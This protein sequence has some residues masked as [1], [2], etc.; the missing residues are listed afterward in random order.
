MNMK[1]I[2]KFHKIDN[3][4]FKYKDNSL[5]ETWSCVRYELFY[6]VFLIK[7]EIPNKTFF[8]NLKYLF[9]NF[10]HILKIPFLLKK[11]DLLI[12]DVGRYKIYQNKINDPL[13]Q[14]FADNNLKYNLLSI[15]SN[16]F[17]LKK[18]LNIT[19][20]IKIL[21]IL[22]NK[23]KLPEK[24]NKN[25]DFIK[26]IFMKNFPETKI[27]YQYIKSNILN[28]Q[29]SIL[30]I[31]SYFIKLLNAKCVI[32][33]YNPNLIPTVKYCNLNNIKTIDVQHSMISKLNILYQ[34]KIKKNFSYLFP[35]KIFIWGQYWKKFISFNKKIFLVT[36]HFDYVKPDNKI[37]K[38]KII[39]IIASN[40]SRDKILDLC[41]NLLSDFT[42]YKIIYKLRPEE[43]LNKDDLDLS[44]KNNTNFIVFKEKSSLE[45]Q[46]ILNKSEYIIG[47]NSSL[48]IESIGKSN[49]IVYG[50]DWHAEY[51]DLIKNKIF[52]FAKNYSEIRKIIKKNKIAKVMSTNRKI[53]FDD[54]FNK[55]IKYFFR[56]YV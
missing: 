17:L 15:S 25:F 5:I 7:A 52:L 45:L 14:I 24:I 19:F 13:S 21:N 27:D 44:L 3:Q 53:Y 47:V 35:S 50:L 49:I 4:I 29:R 37:L 11:R 31:I 30:I 28:Y 33:F 16:N 56:K 9:F 46:D 6:Q 1:I 38:D 43:I 22:L 48:L 51:L 42:K 36:G 18:Q 20:I 2:K 34:F 41:K 32:F 8:R 10:V 39:T 54:G 12:I 55:K 26:K 40:Y 23:K